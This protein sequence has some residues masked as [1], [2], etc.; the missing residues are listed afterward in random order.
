MQTGNELAGYCYLFLRIGTL[1]QND[2]RSNIGEQK[3]VNTE[4]PH[5]IEGLKC[6][7]CGTEFKNLRSFKCHNWAYAIG[8][9]AKVIS[10]M[11]LNTKKK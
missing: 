10:T 6:S 1:C 8:D 4:V 11:E 9:I 5:A 3:F 7:K 2:C